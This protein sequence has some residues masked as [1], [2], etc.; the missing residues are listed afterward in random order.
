[1]L[2]T[3]VPPSA[4]PSSK[5]N[6]DLLQSLTGRLHVELHTIQKGRL[7]FSPTKQTQAYS[8]WPAAF[9]SSVHSI[10]WVVTEI[11]NLTAS[12]NVASIAAKMEQQLASISKQD[13][14]QLYNSF[15]NVIMDH[16]AITTPLV[17]DLSCR[18]WACSVMSKTSISTVQLS[19]E[20]RRVVAQRYQWA[21]HYRNLHK[22]NI[23]L[24]FQVV[25]HDNACLLELLLSCPAKA[26]SAQNRKVS[27]LQAK[28]T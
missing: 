24:E 8:K 7:C 3:A 27:F 9:A 20:L 19:H 1:M 16:E 10:R 23:D 22:G 17:F 11:T 26:P 6:R 28:L 4:N 21:P 2:F 15:G 12:D 13:I 14:L 5:L 25:L 18:R